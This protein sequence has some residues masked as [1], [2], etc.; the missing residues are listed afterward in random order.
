MHFASAVDIA[1]SSYLFVQKFPFLNSLGMH[2]EKHMDSLIS[3]VVKF[4][5]HKTISFVQVN[6]QTGF[7][8]PLALA[9][10]KKD[11]L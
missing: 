1:I 2:S 8:L 3:E 6:N 9:L 4:N 10:V 5:N 11:I 7:L